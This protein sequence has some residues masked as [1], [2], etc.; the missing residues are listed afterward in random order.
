[1][2]SRKI[3][4]HQ[5]V[6][7]IH[8]L[9]PYCLCSLLRTIFPST[10][11]ILPNLQGNSHTFDYGDF[12][13]LIAVLKLFL[14]HFRVTVLMDYTLLQERKKLLCNWLAIISVHV[15]Y[16]NDKC[17]NISRSELIQILSL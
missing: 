12:T 15:N 4:A 16:L 3:P 2:C 8:T 10:N 17:Q 5:C 9:K 13:V 1:M 11:L 7:A 6:A 14:K